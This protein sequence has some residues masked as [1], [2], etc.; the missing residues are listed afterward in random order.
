MGLIASCTFSVLDL[1]ATGNENHSS[2]IYLVLSSIQGC[3]WILCSPF[4]PILVALVGVSLLS[5]WFTVLS[6]TALP[7]SSPF[8]IQHPSCL[9]TQS[10]LFYSFTKTVKS[11]F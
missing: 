11:T 6:I 10:L 8:S 2:G 5:H 9:K 3:F 4:F 1:L 7:A